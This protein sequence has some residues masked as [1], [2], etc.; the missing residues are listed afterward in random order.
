MLTDSGGFQAF[1][2]TTGKDSLVKANGGRLHLPLASRRHEV[3][4]V[5]RGSGP[6]AR[7]HRRRHPDAARC[8]RARA[9]STSC[10]G[11]RSGGTAPRD[12]PSGHL[13]RSEAREDKRCSESCRVHAFP[14]YGSA[15]ADELGALDFDGLA[16]GG[17]SV[18]EPIR[19]ACTRH[20]GRGRRDLVDSEAP[21][22]LDGGR[23][24]AGP[25]D[26]GIDAWGRHVRLRIARRETPETARRSP[27]T[28]RWSSSRPV[29]KDDKLP[30]RSGVQT[31]PCCAGGYLTR[32]FAA[33]L[34]RGRNELLVLRLFSL[35]N[36]HF[37]GELVAWR[38]GGHL[39]RVI[40]LPTPAPR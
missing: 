3:P 17:F 6:R 5:A 7:P 28:A 26:R 33:P 18:G 19:E 21:A 34:R 4:P 24:P 23:H 40:T 38:P 25:P 15:H 1:S 30:D 39:D 8:L 37:Y 12:G 20:S 2:L 10:R 35:H 36:L 14:I 9:M 22:L 11:R 31:A 27:A 29:Y 13:L 32:L 16:L